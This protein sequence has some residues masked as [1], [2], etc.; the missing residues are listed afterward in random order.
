MV[1]GKNGQSLKVANFFGFL[2]KA[3]DDGCDTFVHRA[4]DA[5]DKI[6][7]IGR[8]TELENL[9]PIFFFPPR[10]RVVESSL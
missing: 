4:F 9:F 1:S 2:P 3:V 7:M 8:K 6:N 5:Q 10:G